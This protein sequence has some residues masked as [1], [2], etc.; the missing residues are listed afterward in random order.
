MKTLSFSGYHRNAADPVAD[1]LLSGAEHGAGGIPDLSRTLVVLP[2]RNAIRRVSAALANLAGKRGVFPPDFLTPGAFLQHGRPSKAPLAAQEQS[3]VWEN[4][5]LRTAPEE[6]SALAPAGFAGNNAGRAMVRSLAGMLYSLRAELFLA[7]CSITECASLPA[8]AGS[9]RWRCLA[10]LEQRFIRELKHLGRPDPV[11]ECRAAIAD[12]EPFRTAEK[13]VFA[14][15]PDLAPCVRKRLDAIDK[16]G[17]CPVEILIHAPGSLKDLFDSSGALKPEAWAEHELDFGPAPGRI[18]AAESPADLARLARMLASGPDGIF[19]PAETTPAIADPSL[20]PF[21]E[22]EFSTFRKEDGG[23]LEVYDP[24]GIPPGALRIAPLADLLELLCDSPSAETL[25]ALFRHPDFL[26]ALAKRCSAGP[27]E[28]LAASDDYFS[29]HLPDILH[30]GSPAPGEEPL[31]AAFTL[32][33]RLRDR[34]LGDAPPAGILREVLNEI[35]SGA[36]PAPSHGVA[37]ESEAEFASSLL[38]EFAG[39]PV[40]ARMEMRDF[41]SSFA[42]AL[43]AGRLYGEH[44][45]DA[46][47]I[48]GF[49]DLPFAAGNRIILCGMSE[50][51]LPE[52]CPAGPFLSDSKRRALGLPDNAS[53]LARDSFYLESLIEPRKNIPDSLHFLA[54]KF[55]ANGSAL[56]FSSLFFRAPDSAML[57]RAGVLFA[58]LPAPPPDFPGR[59]HRSQPGEF[60]LKAD[61]SKA[62]LRNGA[63]TLSVTAFKA[64]LASPLRAFLALELGMGEVDYSSPEMDPLQIGSSCHAAL[65]NLTESELKTPD[66]VRAALERH[67]A[68]I[69]RSQFGNPLPV[70]VDTQREL[71]NQRLAAAAAP[72]AESAREFRVL[73]TEWSLNRGRGI[74]WESAVIRGRIDRIEIAPEKNLIRLIDFKTSDRGESPEE[75][76]LARRRG[77]ETSFT[78]LQLPLYRILLPLDEA[79][80]TLLSSRFPGFRLDEKTAIRCGYFNLPKNVTDTGYRM[81]ENLDDLLGNAADAARGVLK[82]AADLRL[83]IL[84]EN[85]EK[86][87]QYDGFADLLKPDPAAALAGVR[88]NDPAGPEKTAAPAAEETEETP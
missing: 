28:L 52:T 55:S 25:K 46:L 51:I 21:L 33:T 1:F 66:T 11:E 16:S 78:D 65:Q 57:E 62:F 84:N 30:P 2:G 50:G 59:K 56:R 18:H 43:R 3:F 5:L 26:E 35:Y 10:A 42:A 8:F 83:G 79:F 6:I 41:L 77:G 22:H 70:F 81:W 48:P 53:R 4:V 12:T 45:P 82:T 85:P 64:L 71:L 36:T 13:L 60:R 47:A 86:K 80:R 67:L 49:L 88:W 14:C 27:D 24:A 7:P 37:F 40:L 38:D 75:T 73:C 20:F 69:L 63:T 31:Q 9:G 39:S 54:S 68:S 72:L 61:F 32:V 76:H 58:P 74:L 15:V 17:A 44:A 87:V 29:A 34:L 23:N 19:D